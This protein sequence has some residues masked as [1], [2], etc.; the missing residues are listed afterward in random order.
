[1]GWKWTATM[2]FGQG[3]K[4]HLCREEL[5]A[6]RLV[7]RVTKH[8]VAV[9]DG[10]I[11]DTGD[12][13]RDSTRCVYGYFSK[14]E[15]AQAAEPKVPASLV[16]SSSSRPKTSSRPRQP[17]VLSPCDPTAAPRRKE[18]SSSC[19]A[20]LAPMPPCLDAP[21][22]AR[23]RAASRPLPRKRSC[24]FSDDDSDEDVEL[25][26]RLRRTRQNSASSCKGCVGSTS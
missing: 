18:L 20:K 1:M 10:V 6:G 16:A 13:S 19:D 23:L 15:Q 22:P 11:H 5:P 21:S 12:C 8:M 24:A 26:L 7:C 4:V 9:I 25:R 2:R 17:K 3:C 14:D